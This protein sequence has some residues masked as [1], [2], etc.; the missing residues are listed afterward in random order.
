ML[1]INKKLLAAAGC[2]IESRDLFGSCSGK[3]SVHDMCC[4]SQ[5][6]LEHWQSWWKAGHESRIVSCSLGPRGVWVSSPHAGF[7][8]RGRNKR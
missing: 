4:G 6:V 2:A 5:C 8:Q 3:G 1:E 7:I